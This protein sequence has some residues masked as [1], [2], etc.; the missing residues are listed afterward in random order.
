L[1]D[2]IAPMVT[3]TTY[4]PAQGTR[5]SGN[6]I[7]TV[8][9]SKQITG[10]IGRTATGTNA[11]YKEYSGNQTESLTFSDTAENTG[12][13][14]VTVANIDK[15]APTLFADYD[16][17]T[18]TNGSVTVTIT[19]SDGT[20]ES[21]LHSTAA[22]SFDGGANWQAS[23]TGSYPANQTNL[24][25]AIRDA[26]GNVKTGSVTFSNIDATAPMVTITAT[27][28]TSPTS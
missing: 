14:T 19:G 25:V 15:T 21:G 23:N 6:V 7:V 3:S 27:P 17:K 9:L 12:S 16:P 5:T 24:I 4:V 22:Y 10:I 13:T 28:S 1:F 26:V 18:S 8:Q 11:Y 20:G 2:T